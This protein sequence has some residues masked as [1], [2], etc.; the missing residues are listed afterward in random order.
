[1]GLRLPEY[2]VLRKQAQQRTAKQ[3]QTG[4][5]AIQRRFAQLGAVGSGAQLRQ[6]EKLRQQ[7]AEEG[8]QAQQQVA[9]A[10]S[11]EIQRRKEI[12]D[13]FTEAEKG[14]AF[15]GTEAE[16]ARAFQGQEAALTRAQQG[17]QFGKSF[18]LEQTSKLAA[19]DQADRALKLE[20]QAQAFNTALSA[21]TSGRD[22]D[23]LKAYLAGTDVGLPGLSVD[24]YS[25]AQSGLSEVD[26]AKYL[27]SVLSS[28]GRL[29]REDQIFL[30]RYRTNP[31]GRESYRS[32]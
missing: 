21:A 10:E 13:Q 22:I 27:E 1:M 19:I 28:G 26:R 31:Y 20:Q 12:Q 25:Q 24:P 16:K 11:G 9:L 8:E 30:T 15:A 4:G 17:E 3:T 29:S 5:E 2:D 32:R 14:R 6:E 18:G 7:V 23:R